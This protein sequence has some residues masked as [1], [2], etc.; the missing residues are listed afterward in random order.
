[1]LSIK[2][3]SKTYR[4]GS[5]SVAALV[6]VS[7]EVTSG[8]FVAVQGPSGCGK[9]TLLLVAGGLLRPDEG[10]IDIDGQDP[11]SLSADGRAEFRAAN[12]GFVFQQFH[13]VPYL[14]VLDN[15]MAPGMAAPHRHEKG[16]GNGAASATRERATELMERFGLG[17][18]SQHVPGK[19][20]SGERQRVAMARALLNEPKLILAD[21][22]TGN[23]DHDNAD[24]LLG[25][26]SEFAEGGGSVLLVTHD[27]RAV[28]L[29]HSVIHLRD[30][31]VVVSKET[32]ES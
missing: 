6:G 1:M 17:N 7:L 20:S 22:P 18:R 11:Y 23:L 25:Y 13:L 27:D 2:D 4:D 10:Q 14:N 21:E 28:S 31:A 9:S 12:I 3:V 26:L 5:R 32:A 29:A 16:G 19:L 30:G 24:T 15:I 8:Q